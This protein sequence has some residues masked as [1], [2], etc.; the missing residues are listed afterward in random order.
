MI[1]H[2]GVGFGETHIPTGG[3]FLMTLNLIALAMRAARFIFPMTDNVVIVAVEIE[4]LY[5]NGCFWFP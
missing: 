5:F 3:I 1:P 2:P 4:C